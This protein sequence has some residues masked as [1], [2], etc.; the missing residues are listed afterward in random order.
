MLVTQFEDEGHNQLDVVLDKL[1]SGQWTTFVRYRPKGRPGLA[2]RG[3]TALHHSEKT[4]RCAYQLM[5]AEAYK[6]GWRLRVVLRTQGE[7]APMRVIDGQRYFRD[8]R[9]GKLIEDESCTRPPAVGAQPLFP[10]VAQLPLA[11]SSLKCMLCGNHMALCTCIK[12]YK[13]TKSVR[14]D[15]FTMN[16]LPRPS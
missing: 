6:L 3:A 10:V 12:P 2:E 16:S 13:S 14:R 15:H 4:A 8:A 11:P 1:P 7:P 5:E 9:T